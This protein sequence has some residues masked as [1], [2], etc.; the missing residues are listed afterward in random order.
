MKKIL[1]NLCFASI[2]FNALMMSQQNRKNTYQID[3]E[4]LI[5]EIDTNIYLVSHSFP[6]SANNLVIK[7]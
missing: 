5:K 6:W 1:L 4:I 3:E 2:I 7:F